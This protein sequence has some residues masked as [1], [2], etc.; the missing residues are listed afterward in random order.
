M[1]AF[2]TL[3]RK[4]FVLELR[5]K[6]TF[7]AII[8]LA[9][10]LSVLTAFGV[11]SAFLDPSAVER[12][13]PCLLWII[14]VFAGTIG[15]SRSYESEYEFAG[16]EGIIVSGVSYATIYLSKTVANVVVLSLGHFLTTF[17]LGVLLNVPLAKLL[18][19]YWVISFFVI[20]AYA[21]LATFMAPIARATR[22]GALLL[23][24][25][26]LPLLFP[27]FFAAIELS[28]QIIVD[29]SLNLGSFW[30]A[31]LLGMNII[32]GVVGIC[33]F[34]DVIKE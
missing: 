27:I 1:T 17:I 11:R 15:I 23:P 16:L 32:Y 12:L 33:L 10:L 3:L 7:A 2:W 29:G 8:S 9:T 6:E 28:A 22:L 25:I 30:V 13:F 31:L 18:L 24:V 4:D 5:T 19:S 26:L 20:L 14:F 34:G 21:L